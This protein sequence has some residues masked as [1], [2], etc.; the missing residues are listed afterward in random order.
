M[1]QHLP[2]IGLEDRRR[3]FELVGEA[4]EVLQI[5]D[6]LLGLAHAVGSRI[7]LAAEEIGVLPVDGH[8]GERLDLPLDPIELDGDELGVLLGAAVVVEAKLA[9]RDAV[10]QGSRDALVTTRALRRREALPKRS[11]ARR[12]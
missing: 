9:A 10:L 3:L 12:D 4:R 5:A 6:R 2:Q 8:L 1:P 7:D 11:E